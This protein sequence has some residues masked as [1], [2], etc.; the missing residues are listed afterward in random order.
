MVGNG[1][2]EDMMYF[3]TKLRKQYMRQSM[4]GI[5][6]L[7]AAVI[8]AV[9]SIYVIRFALIPYIG[10]NAQIV[11]SLINAVQIQVA[12]LIY[13]SLA[14]KLNDRENHRTETMHE[15][16]LIS[17]VFLFEFVNNYASFFYL[18]FFAELFHDCP[19][20]DAGGCMLPLTYN[21]AIIFVS[22]TIVGNL[23]SFL[24][25]YATVLHRRREL[26]KKARVHQKDLSCFSR[27][28]LEFTLEP[29]DTQASSIEDFTEL[30]IQFGY[31]S[32]FASALPMAPFLSLLSICVG[33][34]CK[35]WKMVHLY[36]R[37]CP[38]SCE[39]IG[40][41]QT[42][43]TIVCV[44]S[45]ISNASLTVFT[46]TVTNTFTDFTR[47][48]IYIGFQWTCFLMQ[49]VIMESIPDVSDSVTI[50][51]MRQEFLV[52]KLIDQVPDDIIGEVESL[53]DDKFEILERL[54]ATKKD[55]C[56]KD[57][58]P[59]G[60]EAGILVER[61]TG[62]DSPAVDADADYAV[63]RDDDAP[64]QA[65]FNINLGE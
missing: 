64:F 15:D 32:M 44:V 10:T 53:A 46:M 56:L 47:F 50:Q 35:A 63:A 20:K 5:F 65:E 55:S 26:N 30:A 43:F 9:A 49:V 22:R 51:Q 19:V 42:I 48:W 60:S 1:H 17:K 58:E 4:V 40:T 41:W 7:I 31:A 8:G 11:A 2:G 28:E 18:A 54:S 34:T 57:R 61:R 33:T 3:S 52:D 13:D 16:A 6:L 62:N 25:P 45:V 14:K 38:T 39:D 37:P 21:L 59:G 23:I 24:L 12:N 36:Q 29:Y 27:P